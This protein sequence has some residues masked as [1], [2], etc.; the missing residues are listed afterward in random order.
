MYK[1]K[2]KGMSPKDFSN[3][4]NLIDLFKN[5]RDGNV[6]PKQI[7]KNEINFKSDLGDSK[8]WKSKFKFK[9]S[10]KCYRKC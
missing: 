9:R 3:Y 7:F 10:N 1:Y 5:S 2:T 8:K 6:N 4:Q